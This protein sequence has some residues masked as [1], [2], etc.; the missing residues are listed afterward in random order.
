MYS[1]ASSNF[2]LKL[3]TRYSNKSTILHRTALP[4]SCRRVFRDR[5]DNFEREVVRLVF[6][7]N[8]V[9]I[10]VGSSAL[11]LNV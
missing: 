2:I 3:D 11:R 7:E 5:V 1:E 10:A 8:R 4:F 9:V 6:S